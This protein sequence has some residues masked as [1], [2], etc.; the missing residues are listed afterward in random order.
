MKDPVSKPERKKKERKIFLKKERTKRQTKDIEVQ[1]Q[2]LTPVI[3]AI[4]EAE[5]RRIAV[6]GLLRQIV[7][8]AP[9]PN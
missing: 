7:P 1:H 2:C 3:L 8:E 6:P 9:P 4:R 5:I